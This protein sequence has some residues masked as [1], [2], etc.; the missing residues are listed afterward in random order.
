MCLNVQVTPRKP[1]EIEIAYLKSDKNIFLVVDD[2]FNTVTIDLTIEN[3]NHIIKNLRRAVREVTA[4]ACN[5]QS[6]C[7]GES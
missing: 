6:P 3:A 2:A 5:S 4:D 7:N 1:A